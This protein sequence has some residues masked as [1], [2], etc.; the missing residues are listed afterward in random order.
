MPVEAVHSESTHVLRLAA[1]NPSR[2]HEAR[3]SDYDMAMTTLAALV[4][5][6]ADDCDD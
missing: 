5:A 4:P 1:Y 3:T 6:I 2:M